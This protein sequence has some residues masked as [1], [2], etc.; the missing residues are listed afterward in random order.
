MQPL[1]HGANV[2]LAS[3]LSNA[4]DSRA[5]TSSRSRA[6]MIRPAG[7]AAASGVNPLKPE[8]MA[9]ALTNCKTP[10]VSASTA[11]LMVVLPAP[12]GPAMITMEG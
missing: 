7:N 5:A 6:S 2:R 11:R 12:L 1:S 10:S 4:N 9:S 3:V 8:A